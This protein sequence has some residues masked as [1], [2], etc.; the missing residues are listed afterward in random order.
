MTFHIGKRFVIGLVVALVVLTI[1][2]LVLA[3]TGG[4]GGV[5]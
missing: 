1:V 2:A 5:S 4:G 3:H